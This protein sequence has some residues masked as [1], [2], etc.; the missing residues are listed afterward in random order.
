M[1]EK[2][3]FVLFLFLTIAAPQ[4][5]AQHEP[6]VPFQNLLGGSWV[7]EGVQLGGHNGKTTYIFE[8][9]LD[10]KL[11]KSKTYTTDPETGNFELRNEGIRQWSAA[12][13]LVH[14]YEFDKYGGMTTGTVDFFDKSIYYTYP[15]EGLKLTDGWEYMDQNTYRLVIGVWNGEQWTKKYHEAIYKRKI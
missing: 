13:S 5:F 15:Y 14:F 1:L 2:N 3:R 10:G 6:F 8:A 11:I 4:L 9:G 12:D 7:Y